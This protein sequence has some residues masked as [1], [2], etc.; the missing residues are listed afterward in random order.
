[1]KKSIFTAAFFLAVS[2]VISTGT[3]WSADPELGN[4]DCVKC[5][6]QIAHDNIA[7]GGMHLS[8]V[9]CLD[10]HV[11]AHPPGTQNCNQADLRIHQKLV[12]FRKL[13]LPSDER[14]GLDR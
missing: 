1:M 6:T 4:S 2:F 14:R 8:E 5:H 9:G 12:Q 13:A 11:G 7:D 3:A 10:C